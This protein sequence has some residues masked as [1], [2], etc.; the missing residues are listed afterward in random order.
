MSD[1]DAAKIVK[2]AA[3]LVIDAALNLLQGDPHSWSMRP[4]PTCKPISDMIGKPFG[5]YRYQAE[6]KV[7][8]KP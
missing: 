7:V 6:R 3:L 5:C 1:D 8:D 2:A 4:C